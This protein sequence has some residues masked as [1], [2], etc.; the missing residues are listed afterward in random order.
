MTASVN[1]S[2]H[3]WRATTTIPMAFSQ[4]RGNLS[5]PGAR[6][7]GGLAT[8]FPGVADEGPPSPDILS[9]VRV[10]RRE[11][12]DEPRTLSRPSLGCY[13]TLLPQTLLPNRV[14]SVTRIP[15]FERTMYLIMSIPPITL[16]GD[17][18]RTAPSGFRPLLSVPRYGKRG[19][20]VS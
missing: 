18:F 6:L 13:Q 1:E 20:I 12:A 19:A 14:S 10:Q 4:G 11:S 15:R 3:P 2:L 8:G 5:G 7:S 17:L 9:G 16:S